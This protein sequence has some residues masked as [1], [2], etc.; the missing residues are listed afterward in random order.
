MAG[1]NVF[2]R[3]EIA[4][5]LTVTGKL[6]INEK[7]FVNEDISSNGNVHLHTIKSNRASATVPADPSGNYIDISGSALWL[8][9]GTTNDRIGIDTVLDAK[10]GMVMYDT[11]QNQFMG[12]INSG[13]NLVWT[14]LGGVVSTDQKTKITATNEDA[15]E[16]LKFFTNDVTTPKMTIN[17]IGNVGIGT[18]PNQFDNFI[19]SKSSETNLRIFNSNDSGDFEI[20]IVGN[21]VLFNSM[22]Q[23][24][25]LRFLTTEAALNHTERMCILANG[26]VGIGTDSPGEK[27]SINGSIQISGSSDATVTNESKIIFTRNLTDTDESENIA[28]IYTGSWV[29]PLILESGR[30]NGYIKTIGNSPGH[31]P[32]FVV[33]KE[34]DTEQFRICGNGMLKLGTTISPTYGYSAVFGPL[35]YDSITA[36]AGICIANDVNNYCYIRHGSGNSLQ[37]QCYNESNSSATRNTGDIGISPYGGRVGIGTDSPDNKLSVQTGNHDGILLYNENG[38]KLVGMEQS[39]TANGFLAIYDGVGGA[40]YRITFHNNHNS[41]INVPGYNFGIGTSS[42]GA[43]LHIKPSLANDGIK[44]TSHTNSVD[45]CHLVSN[46]NS[47][48]TLILK[49]A[50]NNTQ[51]LLVGN[52]NA[53]NYIMGNVG[54]GETTPEYTLEVNGTIGATGDI[55]AFHSSDKRLKNNLIPIKDPLEKLKKINGYTFVWKENEH[56]PNK[57]SDIGVVAQEVEEILPEVTTT[58]QNGYKAVRYEKL[59]PFLISCI[60]EQQK[61]IENQQTQITSLQS[62]IDELKALIKK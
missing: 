18:S 38:Y 6:L 61:Q 23:D 7:L 30:G 12:I 62:Q 17:Q 52:N 43:K 4:E 21:D 53:D 46:S 36:N 51:V 25:K 24:G 10:A 15:D 28:K 3:L 44:V 54:I 35:G 42:P 59:T 55:T 11:S 9:R 50:G 37:I 56:H 48:G 1:L 32:I 31:N 60:K 45:V 5:D 41:F 33:S 26:N 57:G 58:R 29:G 40:S 39:S 2:S 14:G 22:R 27:L 47:K 20:R 16:G 8:P 19:L 49:D 34:D 13:G